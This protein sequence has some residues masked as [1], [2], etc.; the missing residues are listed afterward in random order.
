M[1]A[2]TWITPGCVQF[3]K[4]KKRFHTA[5]VK[6]RNSRAEHM[7]RE[8]ADRINYKSAAKQLNQLNA[9]FAQFFALLFMRRHTVAVREFCG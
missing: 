3:L 7:R 6:R 4:N 1:V 5:W 8:V 9:R 2:S